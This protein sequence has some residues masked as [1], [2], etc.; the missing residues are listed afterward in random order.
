GELSAVEWGDTHLENAELW[1]EFDERLAVAFH[2]AIGESANANI[3]VY[4]P[5]NSNIRDIIMTDV[6]RLR[7]S[8]LARPL[9]VPPDAFRV[10]DNG[11]AELYHLRP[12]TPY[13]R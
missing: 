12:Q 4:G 13:Q 9:P 10:Y 6:T 7:G 5:L 8:R 11:T 3:F 2:T 1:T